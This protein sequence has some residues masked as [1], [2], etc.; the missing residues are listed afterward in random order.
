[1][2]IVAI[3]NPISGAGADATVASRRIAL[4]RSE[5]ER[6]GL[7]A[8]IHLT[9]RAGHARELAAESAA[10]GADL[11]IVW[12][13]DGTLNEAG[14]GLLGSDTAIALVRAGSGN[15]LA[16]AL[17]V[18]RDPRAALADALD[19]RT[20]TI[21]AGMMA[22]RAFF[23]IAGIGFDARVA[24]QFNLRTTGRRGAWPY[25]VIGVREGCRY[26]AADYRLELDGQV[27]RVRALLIAFANGREYG[28]GARISPLAELDDGLL[29][30]TVVEERSVL[31]RFWHAPRLVTGTAHL[32]SG[33][34][35][36]RITTAS[37]EA[38]EP[39]EFHVDGEPGLA[40]GR[41]DVRI[42]PGAL[43]VRTAHASG[44]S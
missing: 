27:R 23:N 13:G 7:R 26:G 20:R 18:P 24:K 8:T 15:G 21:D 17:R 40:E 29:D 36:T 19:G 9:E 16:G 4:V 6:R 38:D 25:V 37:V 32:A 33:V 43:K 11:V 22:G 30:A 5:V 3:I 42:L 31:A 10:A 35:A 12:G 34:F 1:M 44:G 41:I 28:M 14:A 39:M 2:S